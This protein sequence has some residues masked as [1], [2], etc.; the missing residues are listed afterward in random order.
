MGISDMVFYIVSGILTIIVLYNLIL[1][2]SMRD[3]RYIYY[4]GFTVFMYLSY[5]VI[6]NTGYILPSSGEF[7]AGKRMPFLTISVAIFCYIIFFASHYGQVWGNVATR[8]GGKPLKWGLLIAIGL[9]FILAIPGA[10]F[11]NLAVILVVLMSVLILM[12]TF[13]LF[14]S[15]VQIALYSLIAQ[16][17][18]VS[19]IWVLTLIQAGH[20]VNY[21]VF[22]LLMPAGLSLEALLLSYSLGVKMME[23]REERRRYA[24][25]LDHKSE[26]NRK[27]EHEANKA[28]MLALRSQMNPH[29]IFNAM[30]TIHACVLD[31]EEEKADRLIVGFSKLMRRILNH[32]RTEHIH[33]SDEVA[34]LRGYLDLE[35]IKH[36]DGLT[37]EIEIEAK[38]EEDDPLIPSAMIQPICENAIKHAFVDSEVNNRIEV[39]MSYDEKLERM[40]VLITDN[41]RGYNAEKQQTGRRSHGLSIIQ[42]RLGMLRRQYQQGEMSVS[43]TIGDGNDSGTRV[44]LVLP[45]N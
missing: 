10:L 32:S 19:G 40:N 14:K 39:H 25:M 44:H 31:K 7:F 24:V 27:L 43:T 30:N 9:P 3:R 21:A 16:F 8:F 5:L 2:L 35:V 42:E 4:L 17:L 18:I 11:H 23:L 26:E 34:F 45:L 6:R 28:Q 29:F 20:L 33:L 37:Y 12:A 1:F 36:G 41:G 22:Y 38:L 15:G 13:M